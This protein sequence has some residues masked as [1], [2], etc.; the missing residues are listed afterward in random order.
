MTSLMCIQLSTL[1]HLIKL[2]ISPKWFQFVCHP[3]GG[4]IFYV[5]CTLPMQHLLNQRSC[6]V[7]LYQRSRPTSGELR[8]VPCPKS[9]T[10]FLFVQ[11]LKIQCT[12]LWCVTLSE[13]LKVCLSCL[14]RI[15]ISVKMSDFVALAFVLNVMLE[16]VGHTF[17][18]LGELK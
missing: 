11:Q 14:L 6:S 8:Y 17:M 15:V 10:R 5:L 12:P 3:P 16:C 2:V 7:S 9:Y 13:V 4:S 1:L 18:L